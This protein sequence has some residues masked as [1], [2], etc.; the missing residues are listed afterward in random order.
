M[1][2]GNGEQYVAALNDNNKYA[3]GTQ[4]SCLHEE[5]CNNDTTE[6]KRE[7]LRSKMEKVSYLRY[8]ANIVLLKKK[9]KSRN[10]KPQLEDPATVEDRFF[11]GCPFGEI[12]VGGM[13]IHNDGFF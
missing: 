2:K 3:F 13:C 10:K 4:K 1:F 8:P 11:G 9:K 12:S 5:I 7:N 6:R